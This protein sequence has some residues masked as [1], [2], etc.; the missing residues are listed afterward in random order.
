[1]RPSSL[2]V[3]IDLHERL[4]QLAAHLAGHP[5]ELAVF[6]DARPLVAE[7]EHVVA[8]VLQVDVAQ[9]GAGADDQFDHADEAGVRVERGRQRLVQ[10]VDLRAF[11]QHDQ[12]MA[13]RCGGLRRVED[14]VRRQSRLDAA[15]HVDEYAVRPQRGIQRGELVNI[16]RDGVG[17]QVLTDGSGYCARQ[18]AGR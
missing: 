1:M 18:S 8:P 4:D 12:G 11:F 5:V 6:G 7:L 2:A 14:A 10:V 15:R 16:G 17:H 13:E 3:E 9:V